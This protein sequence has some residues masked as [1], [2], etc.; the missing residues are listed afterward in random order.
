MTE[1]SF[2]RILYSI[3]PSLPQQM[4]FSQAKCTA[5]WRAGCGKMQGG[6][7][8]SWHQ[9]CPVLLLLLSLSKESLESVRS[10]QFQARLGTNSSI[11]LPAE[12]ASF[13]SPFS[14]SCRP[15][16]K[17]LPYNQCVTQLYLNSSFPHWTRMWSL[18]FSDAVSQPYQLLGSGRPSSSLPQKDG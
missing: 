11:L 18:H 2:T 9:V 1:D 10:H 8:K 13:P 15:E 6:E 5:G 7:G 12:N 16:M 17:H 14:T 4:N 3:S